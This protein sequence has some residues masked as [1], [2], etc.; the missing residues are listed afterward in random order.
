MASSVLAKLLEFD[1]KIRKTL[2]Q[3]EILAGVDEAGRGPLAGPVVAAAVILPSGFAFDHLNDSKQVSPLRREKL[4]YQICQNGCVGVGTA[5]EP[6]IDALNIYQATRLAMKRAVLALTRTPA[7]LLID[8]G[9]KLDI[10][11]PQKAVIKGDEKSACIAAASIVAKVYR[12]AW[13]GHL[14]SLYPLY[15][16]KQHK[17]YATRAHLTRLRKFGPSPVHRMSFSPVRD[18]AS[19]AS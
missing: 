18:A 8:G 11:L 3:T 7:L 10:P 15:A 1:R 16:F 19:V 2:G 5:G 9:M 14:D 6:E 17:G 4:F 12:D 13:M